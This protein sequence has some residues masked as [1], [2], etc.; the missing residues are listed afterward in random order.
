MALSKTAAFLISF[1]VIGAAFSAHAAGGG[2]SSES[3]LPAQTQSQVDPAQ[4]Y[5]DGL[6]ALQAGDYKTAERRFG[7]VLKRYK[8]APG[9][10]LLHGT[11]ETWPRE[12]KIVNS[13]F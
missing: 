10:E 8:R 5:Q 2:S 13:L 11:G 4:A 3:S 9:S 6:A 1:V 7:E 12:R